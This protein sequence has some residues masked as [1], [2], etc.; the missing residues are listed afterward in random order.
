VDEIWLLFVV[1]CYFLCFVALW[2]GVSGFWFLDYFVGGLVEHDSFLGC[3]VM[4]F[5]GF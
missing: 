3:A 5:Q 1:F 2:C 4:E